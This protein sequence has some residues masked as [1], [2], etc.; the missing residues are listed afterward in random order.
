MADLCFAEFAK[1]I[2]RGLQPPNNDKDVVVLLLG[3]ITERSEVV[4]RKGEPVQ[5]RPSMISDLMNRRVNVHQSI[6]DACS[7]EGILEDA[8]NHFERNVIPFLNPFIQY[9][10]FEELHQ[11]IES[12]DNAARRTKEQYIHLLQEERYAEFLARL[13]MYVIHRPNYIEDVATRDHP[14]DKTKLDVMEGGVLEMEIREVIMGLSDVHEN[15]PLEELPLTALR[16]D[17]KIRQDNQLL[18][19]TETA[20]AM[21]YYNYINDLFAHVERREAGTFNLIASEIDVAYRTL[22]REHLSQEE[23]VYRLEQWVMRRSGVGID[24]LEACRVVIAFFIQNCEVFRE[25]P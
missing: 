17:K 13:L 1:C 22:E 5:L 24:R 4:D 12:A 8:V 25:I 14:S 10:M 21:K 18:L 11:L 2:Q 23:I 6:K 9:D 7:T 20:F 19:Q 16:L 3:W 15:T